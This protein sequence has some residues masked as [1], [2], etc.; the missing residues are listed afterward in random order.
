MKESYE[1]IF[2]QNP[3]SENNTKRKRF[4]NKSTLYRVGIKNETKKIF[5]ERKV[6]Y[7]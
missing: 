1:I 7:L 2:H 5:C 3:D 6:Q 4:S